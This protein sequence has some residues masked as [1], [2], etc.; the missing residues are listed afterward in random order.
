MC[1]RSLRAYFASPHLSGVIMW[2]FWEGA[3]F[4]RNTWLV[5]LDWTLNAAGERLFGKDGLLS[6]KWKTQVNATVNTKNGADNVKF[7]GFH[8]DYVAYFGQDDRCSTTF[9]V[10]EGR[11][12]TT[13]RTSGWRCKSGSPPD[14]A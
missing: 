5:N 14:D 10:P 12:H 4:N 2:G 8:G 3:I 9:T 1:A 11:A 7:R 6:N 13:I